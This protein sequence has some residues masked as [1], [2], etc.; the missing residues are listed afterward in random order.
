[1][2]H[3]CL[4]YAAIYAQ[5]IFIRSKSKNFHAAQAMALRRSSNRLDKVLDEICEEETQAAEAPDANAVVAS[6]VGTYLE[7]FEGEA[8]AA[9]A[10]EA[11]RIESLPG[12]KSEEL[13]EVQGELSR[14]LFGDDEADYDVDD[15]ADIGDETEKEPDV[16]EDGADEG[17]PLSPEAARDEASPMAAETLADKGG[18]KASQNSSGRGRAA[19]KKPET[20]SKKAGRRSKAPLKRPASK[21]RLFIFNRFRDMS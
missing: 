20:T 10:E 16:V 15:G 3:Q 11:E 12:E 2:C 14:A 18:E 7:A 8:R 9:A 4:L 6:V 13:L 19:V 5:R 17:K 1:M 21:V